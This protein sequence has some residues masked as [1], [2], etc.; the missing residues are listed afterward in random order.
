MDFI[1]HYSQAIEMDSTPPRRLISMVR[2]HFCSGCSPV[3]LSLH[4]LIKN[5]KI[6]FPFFLIDTINYAI[7][8]GF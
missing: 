2:Y 1:G 3:G 4:Y 8:N 7:S 5:N 6:I